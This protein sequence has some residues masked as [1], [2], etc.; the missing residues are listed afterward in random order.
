MCFVMY[1]FSEIRGA[2]QRKRASSAGDVQQFEMRDNPMYTAD[3]GPDGAQG[4]GLSEKVQTTGDLLV[5]GES[6]L[7]SHHQASSARGTSVHDQQH[8]GVVAHAETKQFYHNT[9]FKRGQD[10][11]H[12]DKSEHL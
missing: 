5:S 7:Y 10:D 3:A 9:E 11:Q 12:V 6:P 4:E 8:A 1:F 2:M